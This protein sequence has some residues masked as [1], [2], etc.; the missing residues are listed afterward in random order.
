[1]KVRC[2]NC[3]ESIVV[4][5]LGRKPFNMPVTEVCDALRLH[6]SVPAAAENLGCS[7]AYIYKVLKGNGLRLRDVIRKPRAECEI[8]GD[9]N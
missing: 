3:G 2:P 8:V 7:R 4:N 5:G 6:R 9:G 1:M